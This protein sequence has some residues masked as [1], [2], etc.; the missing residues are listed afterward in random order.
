MARN[1]GF[2]KYKNASNA[3]YQK[4]ADIRQQVMA[5]RYGQVPEG[6]SSIAKARSR[7]AS[8][9][10]QIRNPDYFKGN[11]YQK[12]V[13]RTQ[14]YIQQANQERSALNNG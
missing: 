1:A 8:R 12:Q 7:A 3:A 13:T 5:N 11:V 10:Q 4:S 9:I 14:Q 2:N 6:Q